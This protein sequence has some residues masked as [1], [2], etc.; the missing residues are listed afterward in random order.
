MQIFIRMILA[1]ASIIL[2]CSNL[3]AQAYAQ[4]DRKLV[5]ET[6]QQTAPP[7]TLRFDGIDIASFKTR[8]KT[9]I[10]RDIYSRV[11]MLAKQSN[12][13]ATPAEMETAA[14]RILTLLMSDYVATELAKNKKASVSVTVD[15]TFQPLTT[16]ASFKF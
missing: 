5:R 7:L 8:S 14:Q 6:M 12:I 11:R 9:S 2:L 15:L 3:T 16:Q 4:S 1:G 10:Q 13:T